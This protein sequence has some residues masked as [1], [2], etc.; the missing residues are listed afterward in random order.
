LIRKI[1]TYEFKCDECGEVTAIVHAS[2][3]PYTAPGW[4]KR[5]VPNCGMTGYT[6]VDDICPRCQ[7]EQK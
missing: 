3:F 4:T 6:Q 1:K 7:Q 5:E 2:M